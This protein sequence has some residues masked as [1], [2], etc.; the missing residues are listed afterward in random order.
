MILLQILGF[1]QVITL[2]LKWQKKKN[3]YIYIFFYLKKI[4]LKAFQRIMMQT[5]RIQK[6]QLVPEL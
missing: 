2:N 5:N 3:I 4:A 1:L 6:F